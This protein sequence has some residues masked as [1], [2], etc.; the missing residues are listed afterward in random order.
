MVEKLVNL[1][2]DF[3]QS[4]NNEEEASMKNIKYR[5]FKKKSTT[6]YKNILKLSVVARNLLSIKLLMM[7]KI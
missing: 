2:I 1:K 5:H 3:M 6:T 4:E 7:I